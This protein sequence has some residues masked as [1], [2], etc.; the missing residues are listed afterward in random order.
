MVKI[1]VSV[2]LSFLVANVSV[3]CS[4]L[5]LRVIAKRAL[6]YPD[7]L[8][9]PNELFLGTGCVVTFIRPDEFEFYYSVR[10]CGIVIEIVPDRTIFNTWL[11]YKPRNLCASAEL[12]LECVIPRSPSFVN[13][14]QMSPPAEYWFLVQQKLCTFCNYAHFRDNWSTFQYQEH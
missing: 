9:H 1:G 4:Y 3:E 6:F 8:V 12:Q 14:L 13:E 5:M 11:T 2:N 10:L 7:E